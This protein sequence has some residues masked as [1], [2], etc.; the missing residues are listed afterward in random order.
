MLLAAL[1]LLL[2]LAGQKEAVSAKVQRTSAVKL[3][4]IVP[5]QTPAMHTRYCGA[6]ALAVQCAVYK[7]WLQG[8]MAPF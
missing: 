2:I 8:C 6:P 4:P 5:C 7:T 3:R 1:L